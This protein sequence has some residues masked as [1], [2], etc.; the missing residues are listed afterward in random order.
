MRS[1]YGG[2]YGGLKNR[3]HTSQNIRD[4]QRSDTIAKRRDIP[5]EERLQQSIQLGKEEAEQLEQQAKKLKEA[6]KQIETEE[7]KEQQLKKQEKQQEMVEEKEEEIQVADSVTSEAI[8]AILVS[9]NTGETEWYISTYNKPITFIK[10]GKF[11]Q[12]YSFD[13]EYYKFDNA[14]LSR[15]D[16]DDRK[17]VAI[18]RD[19]RPSLQIDDD[20]GLIRVLTESNNKKIEYF[21]EYTRDIDSLLKFEIIDFMTKKK[22]VLSDIGVITNDYKNGIYVNLKKDALML[23]IRLTKK[24]KNPTVANAVS[25]L[26]SLEEFVK[27]YVN[28]INDNSFNIE[29]YK[30]GEYDYVKL[31]YINYDENVDEALRVYRRNQSKIRNNRMTAEPAAGPAAVGPPVASAS[32]A[33]PKSWVS[34]VP[35]ILTNAASSGASYL[36]ATTANWLRKKSGFPQDRTG[37]GM[38]FAQ[39]QASSNP[40]TNSYLPPNSTYVEPVYTDLVYRQGFLDESINNPNYSGTRTF[41]PKSSEELWKQANRLVGEKKAAA[42]NKMPWFGGKKKSKRKQR[43]SRK[44][45]KSK[46]QRR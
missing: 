31:L 8:D 37:T 32:A 36:G 40:P 15:E 13:K 41:E 26:D 27:K 22:G 24:G 39:G 29:N 19:K 45:K 28:G 10:A 23:Y 43:I 46:K 34:Y 6:L 16:L 38:V 30:N 17:I 1:Q 2:P 11:I 9:S 3:I 33:A 35:S 18:S 7:A 14:I 20:N 42:D 4:L 44:Q 12:K 25:Q 5:F 21:K